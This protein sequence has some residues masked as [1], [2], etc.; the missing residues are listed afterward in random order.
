MSRIFNLQQEIV[1]IQKFMELIMNDFSYF[2]CRGGKSKNPPSPHPPKCA[3]HPSSGNLGILGSSGTSCTKPS[4]RAAR[5]ETWRHATPIRPFF[6]PP[7]WTVFPC[8]VTAGM[9]PPPKQQVFEENTA[10]LITLPKKQSLQVNQSW[11]KGLCVACFG[12]TRLPCWR[13]VDVSMTISWS[14]VKP[15]KWNTTL[16]IQIVDLL[17]VIFWSLKNAGLYKHFLWASHQFTIDKCSVFFLFSERKSL[18]PLGTI[19]SYHWHPNWAKEKK[20]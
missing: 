4:V 12:M 11:F 3:K 8:Q 2:D 5:T 20:Q 6:H 19:M 14:C 1:K 17:V 13:Y 9:I 18:L 10:G 16:A 15:C 7:F